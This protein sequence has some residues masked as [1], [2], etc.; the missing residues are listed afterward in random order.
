[1]HHGSRGVAHL[2]SVACARAGRASHA[3]PPLLSLQRCS[4]AA[5]QAAAAGAQLYF[6]YSY[7]GWLSFLFVTLCTASAGGSS[8]ATHASVARSIIPRGSC[9]AS[10]AAMLTT[11]TT[12]A[13]QRVRYHCKLML[14]STRHSRH[15]VASFVSSL[16]L[17][18]GAASRATRAC[19]V[20]LGADC[21]AAGGTRAGGSSRKASP[22][23]CASSAPSE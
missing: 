3:R 10:S 12:Q 21:G 7:G 22:R 23:T 13:R 8:L 4:T 17:P 15:I 11:Q 20:R 2:I 18:A 1:M 16:L 19:C 9:R 6:S 5:L 14:M